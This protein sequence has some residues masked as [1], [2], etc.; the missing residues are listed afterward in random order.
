MLDFI[1]MNVPNDLDSDDD[2]KPDNMDANRNL[3]TNLG[4][5]RNL[6]MDF[7]QSPTVDTF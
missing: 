1:F 2:M 5:F 3:I 7:S 4:R 6:K